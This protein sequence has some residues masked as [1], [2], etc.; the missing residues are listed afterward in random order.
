M[1]NEELQRKERE[2]REK[3]LYKQLEKQQKKLAAKGIHVDIETLKKDYETQRAGGKSTLNLEAALAAASANEEIDVVGGIDDSMDLDESDVEGDM[4]GGTNSQQTQIRL[5]Q[6]EADIKKKISPFSI[7]S[8]LAKRQLSVQAA[9]VASLAN[10]TAASTAFGHIKEEKNSEENNNPPMVSPIPTS[11]SSPLSR[12]SMTSPPPSTRYL[13][14]SPSPASQQPSMPPTTSV[15]GLHFPIPIFPSLA[16][17]S[18]HPASGGITASS[19][20]SSISQ[21]LSLLKPLTASPEKQFPFLSKFDPSKISFNST[22]ASL[23]PEPQ[24][25]V[26]SEDDVEDGASAGIIGGRGPLCCS[27]PTDQSRVAAQFEA[28]PL[29]SATSPSSSS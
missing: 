11:C 17:S 12:G 15:S 19:V 2:R 14:P 21:E 10:A 25:L 20:A 9:A 16:N 27:S 28:P 6:M 22:L 8:L 1:S 5:K 7:E 26:E 24:S 13:S 3:K 23:Q 18:N 29:A 4:I